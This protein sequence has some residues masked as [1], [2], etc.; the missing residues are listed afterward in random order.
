M[1][2]GLQMV[3]LVGVGWT[4]VLLVSGLDGFA[5]VFRW[6]RQTAR[7]RVRLMMGAAIRCWFGWE[8]LRPPLQPGAVASHLRPLLG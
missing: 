2:R 7:G 4:E 8:G 3:L 6:R 5:A 1:G